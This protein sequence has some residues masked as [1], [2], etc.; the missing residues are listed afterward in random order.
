MTKGIGMD[1]NQIKDRLAELQSEMDS[2]TELRR[3]SAISRAISISTDEFAGINLD[4]LS[5]WAREMK[6]LNT[7]IEKLANER[8]ELRAMRRELRTCECNCHSN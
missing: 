3:N 6:M 2:L 8:R 1:T 4:E 5:Y 7:Q